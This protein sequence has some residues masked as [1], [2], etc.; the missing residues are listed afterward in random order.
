MG[1]KNCNL[2]ILLDQEEEGWIAGQNLEVR[3]NLLCML[4]GWN[5]CSSVFLLG[6]ELV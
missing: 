4:A 3:I 1:K 6:T 5:F 2:L